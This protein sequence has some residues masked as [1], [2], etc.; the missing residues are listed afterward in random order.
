MVLDLLKTGYQP[1]FL[2]NT[3]SSSDDEGDDEAE[4]FKITFLKNNGSKFYL[5]SKH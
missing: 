5:L 3:S 2:M 1:D 4:K